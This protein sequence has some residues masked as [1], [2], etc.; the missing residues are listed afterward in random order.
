[1]SIEDI[2][3]ETLPALLALTNSSRAEFRGSGSA[4]P[5]ERQSGFQVPG[6]DGA[7]QARRKKIEFAARAGPAPASLLQRWR[8]WIWP[9]RSLAD[10]SPWWLMLRSDPTAACQ[11]ARVRLNQ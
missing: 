10:R 7:P 1:M 11:C 5:G 6:S 4:P 2:D 3:P 9:L 8:A